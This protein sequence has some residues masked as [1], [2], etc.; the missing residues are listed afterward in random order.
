MYLTVGIMRQGAATDFD[1]SMSQESNTDEAPV[2]WQVKVQPHMTSGSRRKKA[3]LA[4]ATSGSTPKNLVMMS[5][6]AMTNHADWPLGRI[7]DDVRAGF[8]SAV[9]DGLQGALLPPDAD[10][11]EESTECTAGA[12]K[13][14]YSNPTVHPLPD[15]APAVC[16][17]RKIQQG[18]PGDGHN[19]VAHFGAL[20]SPLEGVLIASKEALVTRIMNLATIG[21]LAM[22]SSKARKIRE[23]LMKD[24]A[25]P[26]TAT[27]STAEALVSGQAITA[28]SRL[29]AAEITATSKLDVEVYKNTS[30]RKFP[31][32]AFK[33]RVFEH[34]ALEFLFDDGAVKATLKDP[35][36]R[37]HTIFKGLLAED[38]YSHHGGYDTVSIMLVAGNVVTRMRYCSAL[39]MAFNMSYLAAPL[40]EVTKIQPLGT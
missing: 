11:D 1:E 9:A 5:F 29:K 17:K 18:E 14:F 38:P 36:A 30:L 31:A 32:A 39:T 40:F 28:D 35:T 33:V 20:L 6:A 26:P 37:A 15:G 22:T 4:F 23:A 27:M 10:S 21:K 19:A 16:D 34:D 24:D 7:P 8:V 13:K 3:Q 2:P 12:M 25:T